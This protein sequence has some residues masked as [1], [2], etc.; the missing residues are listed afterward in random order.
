MD[1]ILE[2]VSN[3]LL[4]STALVISFFVVVFSELRRKASGM[5]NVEPADAVKL[6]NNDALVVDIRSADAYSRG[7]IV[8]ARNI[9]TDELESRLA[10]LEKY[11]TKPVV[12]VCDAGISSTRAVTTLRQNGFESAYGLKGGMSG[13]SQAGLPVVTGKKTKS[14]SGK[15]KKRG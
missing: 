4:L 12:T 7:H 15:N 10:S 5:V 6:I 8:N 9:P 2:F 11:K 1:R 14:K 3:H 13:W